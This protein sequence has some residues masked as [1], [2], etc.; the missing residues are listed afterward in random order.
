MDRRSIP[1]YRLA[2]LALAAPTFALWIFASAQL[3][4]DDSSL[5]WGSD[6][7]AS[8]ERFAPVVQWATVADPPDSGLKPGDIISEI[9]GSPAGFAAWNHMSRGARNGQIVRFGIRRGGR[10]LNVTEQFQFSGLRIVLVA[11]LVLSVPAFCIPIMIVNPG[12][13]G[14]HSTGVWRAACAASLSAHLLSAEPA[15]FA[16]W[17]GAWGAPLWTWFAAMAAIGPISWWTVIRAWLGPVH[18]HRNAANFM[19]GL[20]ITLGLLGCML[21]LAE[22]FG[23]EAIA[24]APKS[25]YATTAI[26]AETAR[27]RLKDLIWIAFLAIGL[28]ARPSASSAE[29]SGRAM[30]ENVF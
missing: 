14:A 2:L 11:I 5:W 8:L 28:T 19:A 10:E 26:F 29:H 6:P 12:W 23:G 22:G 9:N 25:I 30:P 27:L 24:A 16:N 7:F 4:P 17:E 20:A 1:V 3:L 15:L 18:L 13:F 21:V